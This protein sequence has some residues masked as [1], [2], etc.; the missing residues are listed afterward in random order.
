MRFHSR[1]NLTS[2]FLLAVAI[3]TAAVFLS[4]PLARGQSTAVGSI[5][6]QIT[7]PTGAA[8][9]G[10]AVRITDVSINTS[11]TTSSNEVGRY[12]FVSVPPGVYRLTVSHPGFTQARIEGQKVDVGLAL[13]LNV[14]L[15]VGATST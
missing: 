10:A 13:T 6:G 14:T 11:Q 1:F 12:S 7:D 2:S 15:Q 3:C 9:V 5:S 8:V 4:A